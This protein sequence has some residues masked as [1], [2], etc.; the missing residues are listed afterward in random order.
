MKTRKWF[1]S[2]Y[3]EEK[4]ERC[5]GLLPFLIRIGLPKRYVVGTFSKQYR[6]P[7]IVYLSILKSVL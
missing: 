3:S 5:N 6:Q 4:N 7:K 1:N 2:R